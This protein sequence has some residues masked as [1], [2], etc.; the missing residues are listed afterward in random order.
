VVVRS[1]REGI[2]LC[3]RFAPE[4]LELMVR[5]PGRRVR[6]VTCAGAIF[7]GPWSPEPAGDFAA[8]PSHVLPTGGTAAMFSGL[9]ADDFRRRSSVI[10]FTRRD[11]L[12]ALPLI[13]TFARIEGLDAHARSAAIRVRAS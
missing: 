4:H 7:V 3:N 1:L 5:R 8:G 6:S 9:T 11:L 10:A 12:D 13:E 2:E